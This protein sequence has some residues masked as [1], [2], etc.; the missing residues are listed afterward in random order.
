MELLL[1]AG[2]TIL[3]ANPAFYMNPTT[4]EEVVDTVV[5]EFSITWE[6]RTR[7][8][9]WKR[10][11]NEA[12]ILVRA[13]AIQPPHG[14]VAEATC[15]FQAMRCNIETKRSAMDNFA[16]CQNPGVAMP[17]TT[18]ARSAADWWSHECWHCRDLSRKGSWCDRAVSP[19]SRVAFRSVKVWRAVSY[20]ILNRLQLRQL[21]LGFSVMG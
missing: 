14:S 18:S 6:F 15:P 16:Q 4:I 10:N 7:S 3:P 13:L 21:R 8:P 5:A 9:R 12:S 11:W 2:A 17:K 19:S 1:L 20:A